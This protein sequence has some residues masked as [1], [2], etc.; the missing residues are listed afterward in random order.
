MNLFECLQRFFCII[1]NFVK[2][3]MIQKRSARMRPD[4]I[5]KMSARADSIWRA[6]RSKSRG[7]EGFKEFE[8]DLSV[9]FRIRGML[10][11]LLSFIN[12]VV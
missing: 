5:G 10:T 7:V 6:K 8:V 11:T 4:A 1:G 3:P 2:F 12:R 9:L